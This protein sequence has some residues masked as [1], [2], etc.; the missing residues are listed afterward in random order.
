MS[1]P[2]HTTTSYHYLLRSPGVRGGH[3]IVEGTRIGVHDVIGLLQNGETVDSI[4][5]RCFPGL[6]RAQV[7]ECLAYYEDHRG[8]IDIL[9]ARQMHFPD[10]DHPQAVATV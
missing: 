5:S 7:Y 2:A 9:V 10:Q 1:E 3:T 4:V 8:E 6:T